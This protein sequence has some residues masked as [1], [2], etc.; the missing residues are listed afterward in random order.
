MSSLTA[1]GDDPFMGDDP[2]DSSD[3]AGIIGMLGSWA[4]L[5]YIII[6]IVASSGLDIGTIAATA[7]TSSVD[8][9]GKTLAILCDVLYNNCY[10]GQ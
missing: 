8:C 6:V 5:C 10:S 2:H 4:M 9:M 7:V 3:A 1:T